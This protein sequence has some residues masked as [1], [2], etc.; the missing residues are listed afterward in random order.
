MPTTCAVCDGAIGPGAGRVTCSPE[1]RDERRRR[2]TRARHQARWAEDPEWRETRTR[3]TAVSIVRR[4]GAEAPPW[5][6]RMVDSH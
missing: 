4:L 1:C 3:A 5:A 2:Q 6:Q